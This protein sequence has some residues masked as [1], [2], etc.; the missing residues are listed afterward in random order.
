MT[1]RELGGTRRAKQEQSASNVFEVPDPDMLTPK[2]QSRRQR[3]LD[4]ALALVRSSEG[5]IEI[6][7]VAAAAQVALGT[8]Y[9][10]FGSKEYLLAETYHQWCAGY[11]AEIREGGV[12][13]TSNRER[14]A[15]VACRLVRAYE[16]EPQ[17]YAIGNALAGSSDPA[18][19]SCLSTLREGALGL[20]VSHFEGVDPPDAEAIAMIVWSVISSSVGAW[21]AGWHS[22]EDAFALVEA[23]A[24]MIFEFRD[25]ALNSGVG[26]S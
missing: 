12:E 24:T 26:L 6:R 13:A 5:T 20:F 10:Y 11:W 15:Y 23:S 19:L 18:V 4:A 1:R 14:A 8:V 7:D 3:I 25:P 21:I 16:R 22:L 17:L 2:Q 9:R